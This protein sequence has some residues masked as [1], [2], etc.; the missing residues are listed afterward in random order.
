MTTSEQEAIA[1][2]RRL[3]KRRAFKAVFAHVVEQA[4]RHAI[5]ERAESDAWDDLEQLLAMDL[6]WKGPRR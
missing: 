3:G 4:R 5:Y 1:I 6:D 2:L